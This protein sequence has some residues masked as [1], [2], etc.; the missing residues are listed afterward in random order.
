MDEKFPPK[1]CLSVPA[2]QS[3][4]QSPSVNRDP[5]ETGPASELEP[6][7][8]HF[9]LRLA[10]GTFF[11][12]H[13]PLA[14]SLLFGTGSR[15]PVMVKQGALSTASL[16]TIFLMARKFSVQRTKVGKVF[17]GIF[18]L[19]ETLSAAYLFSRILKGWKRGDMGFEPGRDVLFLL[20]LL[21]C[22]LH[23]L[24]C[25]VSVLRQIVNLESI[26]L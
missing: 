4:G 19:H 21:F 11:C 18:L 15:Y 23:C 26:L 1:R 22:D 8:G 17:L 6:A 14:T 24:L 25:G 10:Y 5:L 16:A 13:I 20:L 2:T 3:P 12:F 9:G 7:R